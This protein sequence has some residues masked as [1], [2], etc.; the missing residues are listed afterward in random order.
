MYPDDYL[1]KEDQTTIYF[2]SSPYDP[3]NNWSPHAVDLWG[4]RFPS[5]EHAYQYKKYVDFDKDIAEKILESPSPWA[6]FQIA[7]ENDSKVDTSWH[8]QKLKIMYEIIKAKV[9]QNEDV[10]Q[11]LE[12]S[13]GKKIVENSPWDS[14]WGVG[15]DGKGENHLGKIWMKIREE[16]LDKD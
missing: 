4:K 1:N 7:R 2:F 8:N 15:K 5:A 12:K 13:D 10:L 16:I 9:T 3:F 6:A 11:Q 14:F